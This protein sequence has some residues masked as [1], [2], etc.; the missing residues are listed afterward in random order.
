MSPTPTGRLFGND[1]VL[2]RTFRAPIDDVWASLTEP[3]RTA[4]WFGPWEGD[5]GPG[6]TIKVQMVLE[7]GKPWFDLTVDACEPPSR[8][9]VSAGEDDGRW[10]VEM[11]LTE[12][13]G[14]TELRFTQ[15]LTGTDGV[16]EVGPGWE[17]YLDALVA[18]RDGTAL[19]SFDDYYPSMKEHFEAQR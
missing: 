5:A 8:L 9:A 10:Q 15:Q 19:P 3:G 1:L 7:E 2:T 6:R 17:F 11:V 16:G 14:V 13:V 12:T 4:R 18:S